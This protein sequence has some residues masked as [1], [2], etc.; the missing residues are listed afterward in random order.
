MQLLT[1]AAAGFRTQLRHMRGNA[2]WMLSLITTPLLT[3]VFV[4]MFLYADRGEL[5]SYAVL[6]PGLMAM[7]STALLTAGELISFERENGSLEGLL[8]A[9]APFAAVLYGRIAA[10]TALSLV[11]FA[12]AWLVG[13]LMAGFPVPVAHPWALAAAVMVTVGAM[14]CWAAV[15]SSVFVL[16]RSARIFQNSL[17]YPFFVL[18]GVLVPVSLL[19][20]WV[21]VPARMVFLSWSSDL[22][23]DAITPAPVEQ[24][25]LRLLVITALGA[26]GLALSLLL[27]D[28]ALQ[29]V[30]RTGR[31]THA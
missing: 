25:W 2:D 11:G 27:L 17:S 19:P 26:A 24:L 16:A 22:L 10:V 28:R 13:S 6:A 29:R 21:E 30:K 23:R 18:G 7:W 8:A 14:T 20:V 31:L 9:P 15:M 4:S 3:M 1:A 5:I 12:E